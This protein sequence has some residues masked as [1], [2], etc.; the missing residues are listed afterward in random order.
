MIKNVLTHIG[1]VEV[2]GIVSVLLFFVFFIGILLWAYR[3]KR[4]D[5]E[6]IGRLP[7]QDGF[8]PEAPTPSTHTRSSSLSHHSHE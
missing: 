2:Y 3:L 4:T 8:D 6:S 5:L 7:L 1:G